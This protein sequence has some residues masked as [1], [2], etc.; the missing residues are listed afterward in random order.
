MC[1]C[2]GLSVCLF[3]SLYVLAWLRTTVRACVRACECS[4]LLSGACADARRCFR[5]F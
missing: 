3:V 2:V 4:Y 5:M 1:I